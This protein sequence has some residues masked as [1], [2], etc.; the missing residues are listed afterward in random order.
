VPHVVAPS[1]L[2][3]A[4]TCHEPQSRHSLERIGRLTIQTTSALL[5]QHDLSRVRASEPGFLWSRLITAGL[6]INDAVGR[7]AD[8]NE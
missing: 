6:V 4:R 7:T 8:A 2:M 1:R 3:R 5:A